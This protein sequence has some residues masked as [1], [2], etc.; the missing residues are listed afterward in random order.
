[1][2]NSEFICIIVTDQSYLGNWGKRVNFSNGVAEIQQKY[3]RQREKVGERKF[4]ISTMTS[5]KFLLPK[6]A[7][8]ETNCGNAIAEIGKKNLWQLWQCHCWK[9]E[10]KKIV[11]VKITCEELKK[12]KCYVYN[13]FTTNHRWLV[14]LA[15]IWI[16]HWDYFF[17]PTITTCYLKF[18]VKIL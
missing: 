12:K 7:D 13:I 17:N 14:L 6:P 11:V 10:E 3:E 15:Q 16:L 1:M 2:L 5:Q 8:R 9:W 4:W 18:V